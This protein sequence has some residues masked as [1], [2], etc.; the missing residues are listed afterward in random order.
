M[1]FN[2][3]VLPPVFGPVM[4]R[5]FLPCIKVMVTGTAFSPRRGCRA[6]EMKGG[7]FSILQSSAKIPL[8]EFCHLAAA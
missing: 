1:V 4:I 2:V 5:I 3:T 6:F 7:S 8:M